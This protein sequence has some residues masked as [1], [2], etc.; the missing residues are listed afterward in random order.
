MGCH[1]IGRLSGPGL[2]QIKREIL[3]DGLPGLPP[4]GPAVQQRSVGGVAGHRHHVRPEIQKGGEQL[5][6]AIRTFQHGLLHQLHGL[7]HIPQIVGHCSGYLGHRLAAAGAGILHHSVPIT[8]QK[9]QDAAAEDDCHHSH[10][11]GHQNGGDPQAF[12]GRAAPFHASS[13]SLSCSSLRRMALG[14]SP[15]YFLKQ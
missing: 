9:Q 12:P 4:Q 8:V 14:D 13:P 10:H 5:I 15:Q 7:V 2:L 11:H 1:H 6:P 3:V